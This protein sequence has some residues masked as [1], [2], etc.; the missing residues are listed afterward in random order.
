MKNEQLRICRSRAI[1]FSKRTIA[2]E[3]EKLTLW[4]PM[5][6]IFALLR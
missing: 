3:K 2:A 1:R 4:Q 6:H 5:E